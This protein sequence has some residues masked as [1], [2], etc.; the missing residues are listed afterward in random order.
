LRR[1]AG[2]YE[3]AE[4]H[5]SSVNSSTRD[6]DQQ[7]TRSET[8]DNSKKTHQ[9]VGT[10]R[11]SRKLISAL[12]LTLDGRSRRRNA[13][14]NQRFLDPFLP[15]DW[16]AQYHLPAF[17]KQRIRFEMYSQ[18]ILQDELDAAHRLATFQ[19]KSV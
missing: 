5:R 3:D 14:A 11:T 10:A 17:R 8:G 12:G 7:S 16:V 6:T 4:P 19:G 9:V 15:L 1:L 2:I 13:P 18:Y